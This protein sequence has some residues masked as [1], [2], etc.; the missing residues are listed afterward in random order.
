MGE[1]IAG[2]LLGPSVLGAAFPAAEEWLFPKSASTAF[3]SLGEVGISL[4]LFLVGIEFSLDRRRISRA[5]MIGLGG[6]VLPFL[7]GGAFALFLPRDGAFFAPQLAPASA[8]LFLGT[9]L[10]VTAFP[11]LVRIVQERGLAGTEVGSLVIAA[12]A[13]TD[14]VAWVLFAIVLGF[15]SGNWGTAGTALGGGVL[16][17]LLVLTLGRAALKAIAGTS[18][19]RDGSREGVLGCIVATVM[20]ASSLTDRLGLHAVF[21]SFLLGLAMPRNALTKD[22]AKKMDFLVGA[23][24]LPIFFAYSGMNT[25][26][27]LLH[28]P[29]ALGTAGLLLLIA[30]VGKGFGC[31]AAARRCGEERSTSW[32]V[33]SL[34]NARGVME[35]VFANMARERGMIGPELFSMLVLMTL[36]TTLLASPLVEWAH[37]LGKERSGTLG[38]RSRRS[39]SLCGERDEAEV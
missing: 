19:G 33:G 17:A 8:A 4:F 3:S 15:D 35:L 21:G 34:M 18:D 22:L 12:G 1:M 32:I 30:S 7:L 39:R 27:D 31:W 13:M 23:L 24:L 29:P 25:R 5:A 28:T 9:A 11:V 26:L 2:V 20:L 10:S 6:I 14:V 16:Y 38:G 36:V 37:T